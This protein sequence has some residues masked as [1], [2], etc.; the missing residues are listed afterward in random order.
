MNRALS[1]PNAGHYF[2]IRFE[3]IKGFCA[4]AAGQLLAP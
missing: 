1:L 2:E 3:S 4:H